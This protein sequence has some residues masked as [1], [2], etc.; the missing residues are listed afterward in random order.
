MPLFRSRSATARRKQPLRS[1]QRRRCIVEPL[2]HRRVLAVLFAD[3]FEQGSNSDDWADNWVEDSQDDWFRSAQRATDGVRSAEVDG[4]ATN[5]TLTLENSLDLTGFTSAELT[6]DWLIENGFDGEEYLSLDVSSNGGA[7][8]QTDV[9]RLSG[10]VDAENTWHTESVDLSS[11]ASSDVVVRFRASVSRSNEDANVDNVQIVGTRPSGPPEISISDATATEGDDQNVVFASDFVSAGSG[12]LDRP[13]GITFGP[14]GNLYA[15]S[16]E[17]DSVLRYDGA[18][19]DFLDEFVSPGSGELDRPR[20]VLFDPNG[21]LLVVSRG[22]NRIIRY[23]GVDGAFDTVLVDGTGGLNVPANMAYLDAT[24]E[25]LVSSAESDD[26]LKYDG[27]TGEF[28]G[29]FVTTAGSGGLSNPKWLL[30][31]ESGDLLV[32]SQLGDQILRYDA[33]GAFQ[34]VF[35]AVPTGQASTTILMGMAW[36]IDGNLLVAEDNDTHAGRVIRLD[37]NTGAFI[38]EYVSVGEGG[39]DGPRSI[40]VDDAGNLY[41]VSYENDKVL[42]YSPGANAAFT[43]SLS[44]SSESTISVDFSTVGITASEGSDYVASSGTIV[45]EP[46]VTTRTIV[47][48]TIDDQIEEPMESFTVNLGSS[49]GATVVDA[50]GTAT[51]EDDDGVRI[52]PNVLYVYDIRFDSRRGG[53]DWRAVFEI[54]GDSNVDG[55]GGATDEVAAGVAI[56]VE[57]AGRVYAGT[58]DSNGVFR[59]NWLRNLGSGNH[60]ANAVDLALTDYVWNP[61]DLDLEDDSD[62]DGKPDER[63]VV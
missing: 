36:G 39:L 7:T 31:A 17:T 44:S 5:A 37:G 42:R 25:L 58:T 63:L 55:Q 8:W 26:I 4:R 51:I 41:V 56:E 57:F 52:D 20:D 12:G 45:F 19:G 10:N 48:P 22:N 13:R 15:V 60:F 2:E 21:N 53:K 30:S 1:T 46:G 9:R 29:A 28:L 23:D 32:V 6:F 50:Q 43:V 49:T 11:F 14:D 34:G 62:G 3:S 27:Q 35:Y 33:S 54:R 16:I 38:N 59:T 18:T 24:D 61:L 47:V 40:L